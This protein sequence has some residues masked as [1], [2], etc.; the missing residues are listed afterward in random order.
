LIL[1]QGIDFDWCKSPDIGLLAPDA[2]FFLDVSTEVAER[3]GGY[4]SERYEKRDFQAK[5]REQFQAVAQH[6]PA[7]LW[8]VVDASPG[9][10]EVTMAVTS[11]LDALTKQ[12]AGQLEWS[13]WQ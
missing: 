7:S 9:L 5:V 3:R 11:Q 12:D 6:L 13:L 1:R 2:V 10:E 8:H 4:G